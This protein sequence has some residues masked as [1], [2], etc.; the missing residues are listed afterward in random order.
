MKLEDFRRIVDHIRTANYPRRALYVAAMQAKTI[1]SSLRDLD[2]HEAELIKDHPSAESNESFLERRLDEICNQ[3]I[4]LRKEPSAL[5]ILD[6]VLLARYNVSLAPLLSKAISPRSMVI[7]C[8]P[9]APQ[10][11]SLMGLSDVVDH[12]FMQPLQRL[13]RQ[14][15]EPDCTIED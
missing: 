12:D 6:A 3:Y 10:V 14:I 11:S 8:V 9:K 7:L 13:A 1:S 2:L 15:G 5:L 4:K